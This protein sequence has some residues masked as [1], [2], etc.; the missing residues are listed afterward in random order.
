MSCLKYDEIVAFLESNFNAKA[1]KP[2]PLLKRF[3][4]TMSKGAIMRILGKCGIVTF[5]ESITQFSFN[6]CFVI[7]TSKKRSTKLFVFP[8]IQ[9]SIFVPYR[10]Y[11][12]KKILPIIANYP[13]LNGI[14]TIPS[15]DYLQKIL[16][17]FLNIADMNNYFCTHKLAFENDYGRIILAIKKNMRQLLYTKHVFFKDQIPKKKKNLHKFSRKKANRKLKPWEEGSG[18]H[19]LMKKSKD[20]NDRSIFANDLFDYRKKQNIIFDNDPPEKKQIIIDFNEI[21][22]NEIEYQEIERLNDIKLKD[23]NYQAED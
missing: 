9:N 22:Q 12:D 5:I 6:C 16:R 23:E 11:K 17:S 21:P 14:P 4:V 20:Y 3:F 2:G 7:L 8:I 19:E 15:L 13:F 1:L 18:F 10:T